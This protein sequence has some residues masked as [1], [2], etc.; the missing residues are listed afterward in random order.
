MFEIPTSVLVRTMP[1]PCCGAMVSM[2]PY[3][4]GS[5]PE[6]ACPD[7]ERCWG[8]DGQDLK[9]VGWCVRFSQDS[10]GGGV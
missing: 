8:V 9:P 3:D 10:T 2:H 6:M 1:C 4:L 7:C 5:G